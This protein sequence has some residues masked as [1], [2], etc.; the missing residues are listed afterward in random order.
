MEG[1]EDDDSVEVSG[2]KSGMKNL[3]NRQ[4]SV[5]PED[6][7]DVLSQT[8]VKIKSGVTKMEDQEALMGGPY[9]L[10]DYQ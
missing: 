5:I 9:A 6:M 2:S 8:L 10:A 3:H 1:Y 7:D 4:M